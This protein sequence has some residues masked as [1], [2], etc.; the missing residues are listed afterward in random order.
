MQADRE[1][2]SADVAFA[3]GRSRQLAALQ[4]THF[5]FRGRRRL[6]DTLLRD[7]LREPA[8]VLDVGCGAGGTLRW[9]LDRGH[10]ASGVDSSPASLEY[11]ARLVPATSLYRGDADGLPFP[12][13]SF[14][15]VL[16]LDVLEHTDDGAALAEARRVVRPG[17]WVL[18]SVPA[19]PWLWSFRDADAGH[20]RRYSRSGLEEVVRRA[21]FAVERLTYYQ[22]ALF[23][24]LAVAR[25]VGRGRPAR[26]AEERVPRPVNALL[27]LVNGIE[28]HAAR[29]I[30]LP[31]GSSIFVRARAPV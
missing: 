25:L 21:G 7:E 4:Q 18:V 5:W 15:G 23:P 19:F 8:R 30:D 1:V 27:T 24:V 13:G 31:W 16:L 9:L 14:D 17:G 12:D 28:A 3:A 29:R 11:A 2:A 6:V 22:C 10:E 26:D 20:L